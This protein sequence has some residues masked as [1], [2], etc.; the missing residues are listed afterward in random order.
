MSVKTREIQ[1][2]INWCKHGVCLEFLLLEKERGG[3]R[4][5]VYIF[6]L[7]LSNERGQLDE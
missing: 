3:E 5:C 6:F 4:E 7:F 2:R 1:I